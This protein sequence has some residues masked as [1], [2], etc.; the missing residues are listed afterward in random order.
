MAFADAMNVNEGTMTSS[1]FPI[2]AVA[3]ARCRPVV[4]DVVATPCF[5]PTYAARAFSNSAT[6]G[7]CVT[8]PL[9]I[10]SKGARASSSPSDGLVMGTLSFFF[11]SV[12]TRQAPPALRT[13]AA[14][15][16]AAPPTLCELRDDVPQL[17]HAERLSDHACRAVA[18]SLFDVGALNGRRDEHDRDLRELRVGPQMAG[19]LESVHVRHRHVAEDDH[20]PQLPRQ[21]EPFA[22]V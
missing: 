10:D 13:I 17:A 12:A 18:Q 5:A 19:E 4:Q 7:P 20:R 1:P 3:R 21:P 22:A 11:V 14:R 15:T 2:P 16:G 6:F 9:L 8:H